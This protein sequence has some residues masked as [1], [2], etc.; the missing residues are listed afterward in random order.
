MQRFW[1]KVIK[2]IMAAHQPKSIVEI[3]ADEGL[4]TL[5]LLE[6]GK[7]CDA[8]CHVIDPAPKFEVEWAKEW[9]GDTFKLYEDLSLNVLPE[10]E[11][12]D[13]ILIDGDHNW[14]TVY[15]ELKQVSEMAEKSGQF[16]I[17]LMHDTAWPY[18]RRDMYYVPETVPQE[19]RHPCEL[20]GI[21]PGLSGLVAGAANSH[22]HNA[23]HENGERNGVLTAVEDFMEES[24]IPL[25]LHLLHSNNGF[26]VLLPVDSHLNP[27][28][29]FILNT[30][31]M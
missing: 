22:L 25:R 31:G 3:G 20:K 18:G 17:V 16:P 23:D 30:S 12:Y 6:Y 7:Q 14:Y 11:Y 21:V 13:L 5:K 19:F 24:S 1:E 8:V 4:N 27:I 2:P 10:I 26:A 29:S 9:Y 15:H 28:I